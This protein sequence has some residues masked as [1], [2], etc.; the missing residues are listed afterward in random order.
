M[1]DSTV[2]RQ[3]TRL[4]KEF[5]NKKFL[6]GKCIRISQEN[7][8]SE[9]E[10]S[11]KNDTNEQVYYAET[12]FDNTQINIICDSLSVYS[13]AE[14]DETRDMIFK[15]NELTDVYNRR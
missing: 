3:V 5:V 4:L 14:T 12:L 10:A 8:A 15:L 13:Y 2:R 1:S 9:K 11:E 6:F 7:S